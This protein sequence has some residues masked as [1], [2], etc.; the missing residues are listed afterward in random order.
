M[1]KQITF[2]FF[3]L[4]L[5][6]VLLSQTPKVLIIGLDGCRQDA[7]RAAN[8]PHI[9]ALLPNALYS[10]DALTEYPTWSGPGWSS[11]LTGVWSDKHGVLE[12]SFAGSNFEDY[13]CL[14]NYIEEFNPGLRTVSLVD[15]KPIHDY[16]TNGAD[17]N[18]YSP[19]ATYFLADEE[20]RTKAVQELTFNNPDAMFVYF[21]SIDEAGHTT[22]F[23]ASNPI[24]IS[25]IEDVDGY[26]GEIMDA[27]QSRPTYNDEDWLV[28]LSPDHGG[29]SFGHGEAKE[30]E[31]NTFQI[32]WNE[33]FSSEEIIKD[34][35]IYKVNGK[36][37]L[38]NNND[39]YARALNASYYNFGT[40]QD[41]TI[42]CRIRTTGFTGD[43]S[44]LSNKDWDSG[45]NKG[46]VIS[47]QWGGTWKVNIGDGVKRIDVE[48]SQ[49]D[50][51]NWHH[52][53]ISA[54]RDG[55]L[56]VFED[57]NRIAQTDMS[58]IGNISTGLFFAM[59][60]DGELN[61]PFGWDGNIAEVRM[62]NTVLDE[63]TILEY[64]SKNISGI[65]P[66]YSNLIGYWRGNDGTGTYWND[67]SVNNN[68]CI[69]QGGLAW[70]KVKKNLIIDDYNS[71]P[72][73]V[74][75]AQ[76]VYEHLSIPVE[77]E[78]QLDGVSW[79]PEMRFGNPLLSEKENDGMLY[80]Y[81]NPAV[82][83]L[84][85]SIPEI[86]S[87]NMICSM[88][89]VDGKLILKETYNLEKEN[90]F[91]LSTLQYPSGLY[92]VQLSGSEKNY[93]GTYMISK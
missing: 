88:Y 67:M 59:G 11:L 27:L 44:I 72:H 81:P 26:I 87:G 50:D 36:Y 73:Q 61:Y 1:N 2:L 21:G 12:N 35:T 24:Y 13:P 86:I 48:G 22:T 58:F 47:G 43:P 83:E 41:F 34:S 65:H 79:L 4:S 93:S 63:E 23:S 69:L 49:I 57:G 66:Y 77:S 62:W 45:D 84:V 17:E 89:S 37:S 39:K 20:I 10:Y 14:F 68:D 28:I 40:S 56:K 80:F 75:I 70:K 64:A 78:W 52:L 90:Q 9:D 3:F 33:N 19:L 32:Y 5:S 16:I 15:W 42:E 31:R 6:T 91:V 55:Y 74:D 8:T 38:F 92:F 7:L 25:A 30:V 46:Y 82:D 53:A 85:I 29:E 76:A 54:D 51:G 60:Q 18:Y 71:V